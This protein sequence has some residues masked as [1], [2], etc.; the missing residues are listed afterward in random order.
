M[1]L[2]RYQAA[3]KV[4]HMEA[5]K[6]IFRYLKGHPSFGLWYT[7]DST[8]QFT[9]FSD[10]DFGGCN[11]NRKSTSGGCQ[12]LGNRLVSWQCRKQTMVSLSTAEAKYVAASACCS[13]VLW[14]QNQLMDY[15]LN[16]LLTPIHIDNTTAMFLSKNHVQHST[17][18]HIEIRIH[19][20][21]DCVEK[22]VN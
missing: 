11:L 8:F 20:I 21:R 22:K 2:S 13:Q 12:L 19:F 3:P 10:S 14:I 15:G 16:F 4:S 1:H 18:K 6:R 9:A 7:K 5:V 17:A